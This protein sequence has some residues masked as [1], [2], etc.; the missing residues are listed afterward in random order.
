MYTYTQFFIRNCLAFNTMNVLKE[1]PDSCR[2]TDNWY[3]YQLFSREHKRARELK[4][5]HVRY[6]YGQHQTQTTNIH[7]YT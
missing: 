2:E 4:R 1:K 6:I 5:A 7:K 3:K